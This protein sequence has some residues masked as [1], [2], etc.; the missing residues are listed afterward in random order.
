MKTSDLVLEL[1]EKQNIT[2]TELSRRLGQTRQNFGKKLKRD[3]LTA[4]ELCQIADAAGA[5]FE[6]SFI[7]PDGSKI[8]NE[9]GKA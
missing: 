3:T 2:I 5:R 7:L 6:V 9:N 1:C 4:D 8:Y